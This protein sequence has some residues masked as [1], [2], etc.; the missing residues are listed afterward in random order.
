MKA[1]ARRKSPRKKTTPLAV[2]MITS[3][4]NLMKICKYAEI[5][6]AS[7]SGLLLVMRREDLVPL[8]LRNNLSLQDLVG[9][10]VLIRIAQMNLELS[11]TITR[12]QFL[13]KQG[14][15]IAI[16]YTDDAPGYWREC[17]FDL[18]PYPGEIDEN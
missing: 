18:L 15:Q 7:S 8:N 4:E 3:L 1:L 11:G 2:D 17:L 5:V 10:R 6:Q 13:G 16:D 12:T 9:I 14:H